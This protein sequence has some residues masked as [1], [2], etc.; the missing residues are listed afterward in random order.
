VFT[1][2]R[3][4]RVRYLPVGR[5]SH[6]VAADPAGRQTTS[7]PAN[8]Y[9]LPARQQVIGIHADMRASLTSMHRSTPANTGF[10][11]QIVFRIGAD[12]W[13]L[14]EAAAR[15][16]GSIQA[17]ALAGIRALAPSAEPK[18]PAVSAPHTRPLLVDPG[19]A[20]TTVEPRSRSEEP[21][22]EIPAREAAALLGLKTGTVSGYI[23]RGRLPGRYDSEPDWR[24]WLT[25]RAAVDSYARNR[26]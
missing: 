4:L 23:R 24:G 10:K 26:R 11:R 14:L 16:H 19:E 21:D 20:A 12:D 8:R 7:L 5:H 6:G 15:E 13:P 1:R 25:T 2:R 17:A 3:K 22:E 9:R 18:P